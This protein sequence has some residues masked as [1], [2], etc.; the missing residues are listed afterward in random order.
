ML[1]YLAAIAPIE[2]SPTERRH[3]A[4]NAI[5]GKSMREIVDNASK[6]DNNGHCFVL[7][8]MAPE[9]VS[10]PV[11]WSHYADSHRGVCVHLDTRFFPIKF[12]FQVKYGDEYP[13]LVVPRTER[14]PDEAFNAYLRKARLWSYEREYRVIQ[15]DLPDAGMSKHLGVEW[16]GKIALADPKCVVAVTLGARMPDHVRSRL[17]ECVKAHCPAVEVWQADLHRSR[18]EVVRER[19]A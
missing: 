13:T 4:E 5:R 18:Y 12:A 16:A 1:R 7:C 14:P 9:T 3:W 8:L 17:K 10:E 15:F 2:G 11:P 19:V 6:Q